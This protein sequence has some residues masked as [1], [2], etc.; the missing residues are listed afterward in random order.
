MR[1][2]IYTEW[3]HGTSVVSTETGVTNNKRYSIDK[4]GWFHG[5]GHNYTTCNDG[6]LVNYTNAIV[7]CEDG[8][9]ITIDPIRI[10]FVDSPEAD[11]LAEFAKAAMQG[12]L[13]NQDLVERLEQNGELFH[14]LV[15]DSI[16]LANIMIAELNKQK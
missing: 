12:L 6:S 5:F 2:V 4:I 11:Q 1:K 14:D 7:E 15:C 9:I 8:E 16:S 10:R 3:V 13:S